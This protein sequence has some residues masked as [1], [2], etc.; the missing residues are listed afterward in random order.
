M[1]PFSVNIPDWRLFELRA[2]DIRE[3]CETENENKE[4]PERAAVIDLNGRLDKRS[5]NSST[6]NQSFSLKTPGKHIGLVKDA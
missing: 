4:V 1:S 2:R 5:E 6:H 3:V